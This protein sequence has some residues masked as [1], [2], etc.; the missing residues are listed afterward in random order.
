MCVSC[1]IA[2]HGSFRLRITETIYD[3]ARLVKPP[4]RE[5]I[6]PEAYY[7]PDHSDPEDPDED[8]ECP[9]WFIHACGKN[10]E[11]LVLFLIRPGT[12]NVRIILHEQN[13]WLHSRL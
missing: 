6:H 13:K 8:E 2:D 1:A 11:E 12:W 9:R 3:N 7:H 4:G 5:N 10:V